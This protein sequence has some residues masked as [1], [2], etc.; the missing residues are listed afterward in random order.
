[1]NYSLY[2]L[3]INREPETY[4]TVSCFFRKRNVCGNS[5]RYKK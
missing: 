2:F 1:M 5:Y 3:P 4:T